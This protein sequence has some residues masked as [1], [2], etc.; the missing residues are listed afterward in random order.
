VFLPGDDWRADENQTTDYFPVK[1]TPV[2]R[3]GRFTWVVLRALELR[4]ISSDSAASFLNTTIHELE[5]NRRDLLQLTAP[6]A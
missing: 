3:Q 6:K 4:L 5:E 2:S 1:T